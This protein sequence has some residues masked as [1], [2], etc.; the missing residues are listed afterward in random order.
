MMS[1]QPNF[2][3]FPN[4]SNQNLPETETFENSISYDALCDYFDSMKQNIPPELL[5]RHAWEDRVYEATGES[6]SQVY[7]DLKFFIDTR[8]R[9]LEGQASFGE[10]WADD[11]DPA[12][13]EQIKQNANRLILESRTQEFLGEGN[14]AEVYVDPF[15]DAFCVKIAHE[16]ARESQTTSEFL[17]EVSIQDLVAS[18]IEHPSVFTP[19]PIYCK[20]TK[21]NAILME[22]VHGCNLEEITENSE[23]ALRFKE[24]LNLER[25][26]QVEALKSFIL[27]IHRLGILH[28]DLQ[29]RNMMLTDDLRW[30]IIDFGKAHFEY[31]SEEDS[32]DI[33]QANNEI[34]IFELR[35][36]QEVARIS[37]IVT[38]VYES[39]RKAV[40]S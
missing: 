20:T 23:K 27:Q 21:P 22:R 29:L 10:L 26:T 19:K 34:N 12:T 7:K 1:E 14:Y 37:D 32:N 11:V 13:K 16:D 17:R 5:K 36:E 18:K 39:V 2:S 8:D 31:S 25:A 15:D 38:M 30:A 40:K 4:A 28:G 3:E 9:V 6:I 35:Q 24:L 33:R